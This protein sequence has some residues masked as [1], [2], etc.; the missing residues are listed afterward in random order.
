MCSNPRSAPDSVEGISSVYNY[1]TCELPKMC[2]TLISEIHG[3][4]LVSQ[5]GLW[6][7]KSTLVSQSGAT[8]HRQ[9]WMAAGAG[10]RLSQPGL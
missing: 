1:K 2:Q 10:L 6:V 8:P 5:K 7:W 4:P 3:P 9:C